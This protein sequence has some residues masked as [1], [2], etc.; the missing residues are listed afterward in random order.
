VGSLGIDLSGNVSL[1]F[2]DGS[3]YA[4]TRGN[5]PILYRINHQTGVIVTTTSVST[6]NESLEYAEGLASFGGALFIS[7]RDAAGLNVTDAIGILDTTTGTI[8]G[9]VSFGTSAD[10]DFLIGGGSL[11][12]VDTGL[13]GFGSNVYA[14][15]LVGP[16]RTLVAAFSN[17]DIPG[18]TLGWVAADGGYLALNNVASSIFRLDANFGL[19]DSAAYDTATYALSGLAVPVPGALWLAAGAALALIP[20]LRRRA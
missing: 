4:L 12:G 1:E 13:A 8:S 5:D 6:P 20:H 15:D 10:H 14:L 2:H 7:W 17:T 19:I 3:L 18:S 16:T 9:S 11:A